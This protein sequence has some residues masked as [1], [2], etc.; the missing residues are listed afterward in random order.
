MNNLYHVTTL[1]NLYKIL[2]SGYLSSRKSTGVKEVFSP[3]AKVNKD[4]NDLH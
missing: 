1:E 4:I 2:S 3:S